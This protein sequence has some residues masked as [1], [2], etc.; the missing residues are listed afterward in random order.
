MKTTVLGL[1]IAIAPALL[2]AD[3]RPVLPCDD[4]QSDVAERALE[5]AESLARFAENALN[6]AD[7]DDYRQI[8]RWFNPKEEDELEEVLDVFEN[9]LVWSE[10][11]KFLCIAGSVP[12][13][14]VYAQVLPTGNFLVELGSLFFEAEEGGRDS[15]AGTLIHE[16][17]HFVLVG[18][19]NQ[20]Q[21][22]VYGWDAAMEL[23]AKDPEAAQQNA[24]NYQYFAESIFWPDLTEN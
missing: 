12:E 19:T 16:I 24:E 3:E 11:V 20:N 23:A 21:E 1:A 22:E 5:G 9:I 13:G 15:Q 6:D 2:W 17:S 4:E 14:P 10:S 8:F 7:F 18:A